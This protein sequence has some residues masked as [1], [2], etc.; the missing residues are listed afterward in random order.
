MSMLCISAVFGQ[1]FGPDGCTKLALMLV[2]AFAES[3]STSFL[4]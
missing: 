4:G 3:A 2:C 1:A